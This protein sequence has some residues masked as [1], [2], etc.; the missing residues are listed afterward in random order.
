MV[1]VD[2]FNPV[3]EFKTGA[4]VSDESERVVKVQPSLVASTV[5]I[6]EEDDQS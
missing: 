5:F 3:T 2:M 1:S 4:V 6:P